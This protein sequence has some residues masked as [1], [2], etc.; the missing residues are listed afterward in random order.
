MMRISAICVSIAAGIFLFTAF[1]GLAFRENI[2]AAWLMDEGAGKKVGDST[3][4]HAD[5]SITGNVEW[6]D[7]KFGKALRFDGATTYVQIPFNAKFQVLN[8]GSFTFAAWINTEILASVRG[9]YLAGAQQ[10][11]LNGL[12]RTWMGL[13]DVTDEA[14]CYFGNGRTLGTPAV[15]GEWYHF[16]VVI[17]EEGD[18]DTIQIY[19]NGKPDLAPMLFG[20]ETCEGDYLL[21]AHKALNAAN[22]WEGPMDD[23]VLI[24]KALTEAELD[25]LMNQGVS[26]VLSVDSNDKLTTAWGYLKSYR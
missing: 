25:Q 4:N 9:N 2:V 14:Y 16:A 6:V 21:G 11:D 12:G 23:V 24:N 20:V 1:P 15:V 3:G 8:T 26:G 17:T 5:G 22:F 7:G 18:I 19:S 10:M 13:Y